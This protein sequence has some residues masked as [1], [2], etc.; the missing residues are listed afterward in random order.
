MVRGEPMTRGVVTARSRSAKRRVVILVAPGVDLLDCAGPSEVFFVANRLRMQTN[1][2]PAYTVEFVSG[3]RSLVITSACGVALKTSHRLADDRGPLDT[4]IV[5]AAEA[6]IS[7]R[8]SQASLSRLRAAAGRARRIAS[9]C[10]GA[11]A[12]A[13][14]GLLDGRRA[15]SHWGAC[16]E[17]ARRFPGIQVDPEPIFVR[18]GNVY[19]SAGST[20]GLDLAL[21]LVQEDLGQSVAA[22]VAR[23]LVMF[24]RRSGG[25]TQF[26][27]LLEAQATGRETLR[28]LLAWIAEHLADDLSIEHLA[29]RS[30]MSNRNFT[31][32]FRKEVRQTPARY[33]ERIRVEAARRALEETEDSAEEVAAACGFGSADSMR[34]SFVRVLNVTPSDYRRRFRVAPRL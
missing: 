20:A 25:Q 24:L 7:S 34:R 10:G 8:L 21:A 6:W 3:D 33:V 19:T 27:E 1:A 12:L 26:S 28:D 23:Q 17:L 16:A 15:T 22:A 11:F 13:A 18:D 14:A 5:P 9:V 29:A 4:L 30:R 2:P 31:R 32:A